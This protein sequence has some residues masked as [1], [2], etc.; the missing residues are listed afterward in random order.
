MTR[1]GVI[2]AGSHSRRHHGPSRLAIAR[3][4]RATRRQADFITETGIHAVDAVLSFLGRV[5]RASSVR[6][7]TAAA[8][9]LP[10]VRAGTPAETEV[11]L[12]AVRGRRPFSPTLGDALD[13]LLLAEAL[14]AG[15]EHDLPAVDR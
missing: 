7:Q 11:F 2:G 4:F 3:M 10:H 8:D 9:L 15:G 5:E 12:E 14:D 1:I 13:A 6:W